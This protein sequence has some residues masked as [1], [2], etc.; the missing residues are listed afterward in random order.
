MQPLLEEVGLW[1]EVNS[2]ISSLSVGMAQ[3]ISLI[4][5]L[6][7]QPQLL[8]LDEPFSALDPKRRRQLQDDLHTLITKRDIAVVMVTHDIE[9]ALRIGQRI[10]VLSGEPSTIVETFENTDAD[11]KKIRTELT[12]RLYQ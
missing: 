9:E 3:R 1:K 10:M 8:L 12:T 6:C 11:G 2:S 7:C 5:A 4:R